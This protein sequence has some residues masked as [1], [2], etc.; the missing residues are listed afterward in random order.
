MID[1]QFVSPAD[2]RSGL[3]ALGFNVSEE[4]ADALAN[5]LE[6]DAQG[7]INLASLQQPGS[8]VVEQLSAL[9]GAAPGAALPF[10]DEAPAA[11]AEPEPTE[12]ALAAIEALER[13]DDAAFAE[14]LARMPPA[15]AEALQRALAMQQEESADMY[16]PSAAETAG[17]APLEAPAPRT[18]PRPLNRGVSYGTLSETFPT[19]AASSSD[20]SPTRGI[21]RRTSLKVRRYPSPCAHA[22]APSA[23]PPPR[24]PP[25]AVCAL[26]ITASPKWPACSRLASAAT[27][28]SHD[29]YR[30]GS[31]V[32]PARCHRACCRRR[33]WRQSPRI[34]SARSRSRGRRSS[35]RR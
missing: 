12:A 20:G 11:A 8:P 26:L 13:G 16:A 15:E 18:A 34:G 9:A 19:G 7:N 17:F 1:Q 6:T 33:G 10:L 35:R 3:L 25:R 5:V 4:E 21:A 23:R 24:P 32:H 14:A 31:C 30:S 29:I 2:F 22:P 27:P 28:A